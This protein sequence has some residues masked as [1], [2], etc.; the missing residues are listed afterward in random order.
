MIKTPFSKWLGAG[1]ILLGLTLGL[2]GCNSTGPGDPSITG[3]WFGTITEAALEL[4]LTLTLIAIGDDGIEGFAEI[5]SLPTGT[6]QGDVTGSISGQ[7]VTFTIEIEGAAVG[8][9]VVFEGAFED[10]ATLSGQ[11]SSGLL[12]GDWPITLEKQ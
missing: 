4:D 10:D 12:G 11:L 5:T 8:G 7:D 1:P 2:S 6:V 9:S 3:S